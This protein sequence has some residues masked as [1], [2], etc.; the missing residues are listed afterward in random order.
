MESKLSQ[1]ESDLGELQNSFLEMK[2]NYE[3]EMDALKKAVHELAGGKA[4]LNS[5]LIQIGMYR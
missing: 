3:R 5:W 2:Q 4:N 1:R